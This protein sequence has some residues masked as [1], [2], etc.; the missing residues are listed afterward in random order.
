MK[1]RDRYLD[2]AEDVNVDKW[3]V[4]MNKDGIWG[5]GIAVRAAA[6]AYQ[7]PIFVW[8]K[9]NPLQDP[10]IFLP[11]DLGVDLSH[12]ILLELDEPPKGEGGAHYDPM[13]VARPENEIADEAKLKENDEIQSSSLED[14]LEDIF[15]DTFSVD[16]VQPREDEPPC[17]SNVDAAQTPD[18]WSDVDIEVPI[19]P[20]P[21]KRR[22][23]GH[24]AGIVTAEQEVNQ[25]G[26]AIAD[27]ENQT[28]CRRC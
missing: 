6:N 28:Y 2:C 17:P 20:L 21:K 25:S 12:P 24:A 3:I 14:V 16:D 11:E 27:E 8:R 5:D 23:S 13:D 15:I 4:D 10:S 22:F 7:A 9:R 19:T 1:N 26:S 18:G